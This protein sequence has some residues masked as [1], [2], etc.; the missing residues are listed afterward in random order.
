MHQTRLTSQNLAEKSLTALESPQASSLQKLLTLLASLL[1][2]IIGLRLIARDLLAPILLAIF[3]TILM[4]PLFQWFRRRGF[5]RGLALGLMLASFAFSLL[6]FAFF[7]Q[8]SFS[9]I[10]ASLEETFSSFR[11]MLAE[12]STSLGLESSSTQLLTEF[13]TPEMVS[14]LMSMLASSLSTF[15]FFFIIIPILSI[16]ILLQLDSIPKEVIEQM[17]RENQVVAKF[18]RFSQSVISY[19]SARFKV[20]ILTGIVFT[21]AMYAL[22]IE[23]ALVWGVLAIILSFIPYVGLVV[24]TSPPVFLAFVDGGLLFALIVAAILTGINLFIENVIDPIIQGQES[25]LS[26]AAVVTALI[27]WTWLFGFVGA[28]LSIPLTVLLKAIL[29][30]Y[31]ETRWL[32]QLMEGQYQTSAEVASGKQSFWKKVSQLLTN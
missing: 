29:V 32:A 19:V 10:S 3:F 5:N 16:L 1:V 15:L 28:L 26:T 21:L 23:F 2:V 14:S 27:F 6:A 17:R 9:L 8:W 7:F 24:A 18:A 13:L 31:K 30:E 12:T 11:F 22:G 4:L 20:N 25:K